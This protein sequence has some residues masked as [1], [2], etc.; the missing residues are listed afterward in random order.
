MEFLLTVDFCVPSSCSKGFLFMASC[1]KHTQ[2]HQDNANL[3]AKNATLHV[4]HVHAV[5][6]LAVGQV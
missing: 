6:T 1:M 2:S 5:P 4:G 3:F